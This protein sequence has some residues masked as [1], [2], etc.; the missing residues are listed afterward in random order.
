MTTTTGTTGT[1]AGAATE[2]R[3]E[4]AGYRDPD[5]EIT[6][7]VFLN[8]VQVQNVLTWIAD[9]GTVTP[10]PLSQWRA[11][12]RHATQADGTPAW[13]AQV[14]DF[15]TLAEKNHT[16]DDTHPAT[17]AQPDVTAVADFDPQKWDGD[18]ESRNTGE[19]ADIVHD[20]TRHAGFALAAV[21]AAHR[22]IQAGATNTGTAGATRLAYAHAVGY[23]DTAS[24]SIILTDLFTDL[25]HLADARSLDLD[26]QPHSDSPE[27]RTV[28]EAML[29]AL[30]HAA[31][32]TWAHEIDAT[33]SWRHGQ[34]MALQRHAEE[35]QR[36]EH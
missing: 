22:A 33:W 34:S 5:G 25:R 28:I 26:Q 3:I 20:N 21:T 29:T 1:P 30:R 35:L 13:T 2:P 18:H 6:L 12:A 11:E 19:P 10:Y 17:D 24:L 7:A 4:I 8:G 36:G 15:Y 32:T 23:V 31:E 27:L 16:I 9:P 14:I